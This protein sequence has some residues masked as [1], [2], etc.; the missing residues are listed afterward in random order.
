MTTRP[1]M[2]RLVVVGD[3][4]TDVLAIHDGPIAVG[5]DTPARIRLTGGGSAANTAAWLAWAGAEVDL[6]AVIGT[7]RTG[8]HRLAELTAAGVGCGYVRRSPD[9]A[10]GTVIVLAQ[11]SERTMVT[12]RGANLLLE[13][14]D[15]DTAIAA[16]AA[17]PTHLHLS[18]YTLL[19]DQSRPAGQHALTEAARRGLTTSVDAASAAPLRAVGAAAFLDW[20]RG[21]DLLL[22]N[23]DEARMLVPDRT[24]PAEC[25]E[26]LAA[27][28]RHAVVKLGPGG[29]VWAGPAGVVAAPA[30]PAAAVDP[31]GAGD[32]FAA[33]VLTTWLA[34]GDPASALRAG[35]RFGARAVATAGGRPDLASVPPAL[36]AH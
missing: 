14:S 5:S 3:L 29:A 12:D 17:Q 31:T 24:D 9:A 35:V 8:T 27:V 21:T 10:T 19:A 4:V 16:A 33:G 22:A 25:A 1:A 26:A 34:G 20:V 18:G 2:P 36:T 15:V 28:A 11:V 7:D 6:V 30:Q 13:P 23:V 32:A